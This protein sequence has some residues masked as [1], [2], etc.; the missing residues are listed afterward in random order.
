M[1]GIRQKADPAN[2]Q[3][4]RNQVPDALLQHVVRKSAAAD[5]G[6][7]AVT[8]HVDLVAGAE[9]IQRTFLHHGNGVAVVQQDGDFKA[10]A[11]RGAAL[12]GAACRRTADRGHRPAHGRT[13]H[14]T[15]DRTGGI[16]PVTLDGDH[17]HALYRAA[18]HGV[19]L[20]AAAAAECVAGIAGAGATDR[21]HADR[22]QQGELQERQGILHGN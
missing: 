12:D 14:G 2:R 6:G 15:G 1:R 18:L 20:L 4:T 3:G 13:H 9:G 8:G 5:A 19:H 7:G 16:A 11:G 22:C 17:A 10:L 21:Q